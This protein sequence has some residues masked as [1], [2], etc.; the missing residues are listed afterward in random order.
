MKLDGAHG[1]LI[2]S[3]CVGLLGIAVIATCI[4]HG[5]REIRRARGQYAT[6][7]AIDDYTDAGTEPAFTTRRD[8]HSRPEHRAAGAD[9][10][11]T[12]RS[13]GCGSRTSED[14]GIAGRRSPGTVGPLLAAATH[15]QRR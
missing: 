6:D 12:R 14:P 13:R 4:S 15:R 11:Q 5:L 2:F 8:R 1:Q 10:Q 3:I 7:T 9:D